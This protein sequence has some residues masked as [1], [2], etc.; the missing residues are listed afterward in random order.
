MPPNSSIGFPRLG[1]MS[2]NCKFCPY[3]VKLGCVGEGLEILYSH[4]DNQ[5]IHGIHS[6]SCLKENRIIVS[7]RGVANVGVMATR[8]DFT[9][10]LD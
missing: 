5:N 3:S 10:K 2:S 6:K 4:T 9:W 8:T 7:N 1:K